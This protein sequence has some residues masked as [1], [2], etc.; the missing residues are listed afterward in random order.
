MSFGMPAVSPQA[1]TGFFQ[2]LPPFV[3]IALGGLAL[4][5]AALTVTFTAYQ[6]C[7]WKAEVKSASDF[8]FVICVQ[9][10]GALICLRWSVMLW[11]WAGV[12]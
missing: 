4:L 7:N 1:V 10:S 6:V 12:L 5:F 8:F 9:P 11:R 2:S 3:L